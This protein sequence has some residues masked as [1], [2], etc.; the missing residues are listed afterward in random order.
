MERLTRKEVRSLSDS[1]IK[2]AYRR[3]NKDMSYGLLDD[4]R[5]SL[6]NTMLLEEEIRERKNGSEESN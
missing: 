3:I 6:E 1:E 2:T 4:K 5:T